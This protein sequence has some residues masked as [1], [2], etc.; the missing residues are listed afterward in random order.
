[1][2]VTLQLLLHSWSKSLVIKQRFSSN[3][4]KPVK[5]HYVHVA[6]WSRGMILAS[7]ARGPGFKSRTSPKFSFWTILNGDGGLNIPD[8]KNDICG[9]T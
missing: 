4:Y 3:M 1:M 2:D 7:G 8:K 9:P 5:R 6:R